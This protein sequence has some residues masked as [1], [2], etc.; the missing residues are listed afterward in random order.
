MKQ[1]NSL[2]KKRGS[3]KKR[4]TINSSRKHRKTRKKLCSKK[5]GGSIKKRRTINSL[6]KN[7]G[8]K[9]IK[10]NLK[11]LRKKVLKG[12]GTPIILTPDLKKELEKN[13]WYH[14]YI[15]FAEINKR[16]KKEGQFLVAMDINN[17]HTIQIWLCYKS[18]TGSG[19]LLPASFSIEKDNNVISI[20]SYNKI[21]TRT[22]PKTE[23][24]FYSITDYINKEK[25]LNLEFTARTDVKQKYKFKEPVSFRRFVRRRRFH[26]S[27]CESKDLYVPVLT[28]EEVAGKLVTKAG[29]DDGRFL[30]WTLKGEPEKYR[31]CVVYKGKL[32]HRL[33]SKNNDGVYIIN[34]RQPYEH[35][36]EISEFIA[37]LGEKRT[38]WPVALA[39]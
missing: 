19:S 25:W 39:D 38:Q 21:Q 24:R 27:T 3:I 18:L 36:K 34:K 32:Y 14:G 10:R 29:L 1:I 20:K 5:H 26:K 30:L 13:N 2:R 6:R 23:N 9:K 4:R 33:I 15:P 12:G 37:H 35:I 22:D 28:S 31:L 16:L 17:P 7:G 8:S 11:S